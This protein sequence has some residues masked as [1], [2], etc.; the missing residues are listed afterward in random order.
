MTSGGED[1][2]HQS[3]WRVQ[4]PDILDLVASERLKLAAELMTWLEQLRLPVRFLICSR[5]ESPRPRGGSPAENAGSTHLQFVLDEHLAEQSRRRPTFRRTVFVTLSGTDLELP[6]SASGWLKSQEH[7]PPLAEGRWRERPTLLRAG[8]RYLTSL[9]LERLPGVEVAPGWLWSLAGTPGE[10]DLV[11]AVWPRAEGEADRSLRRRM[12]GLRARELAAGERGEV[13]DPRLQAALDSAARL[14][15]VLARSE[16][17][18]FDLAITV[19]V[20]GDTSEETRQVARQIHSRMTALRAEVSPAWCTQ[21]P[22]RLQTELLSTRPVGPRRVVQSTELASFWPWLDDWDGR[23]VG[24]VNLGRHLRTGAPVWLNLHDATAL[25][26]ANL[27]VV[28][29]SGSGKSYLGGLLGLEAVRLGVRTVVLDPENEHRRWCEAVA[30]QYLSLGESSPCGF[31]LLEMAEPG[32]APSAV[33]ELISLLCGQ[34][35]PAEIGQV[36]DAVRWTLAEAGSGTAMLSD[37]LPRLRQSEIGEVVAHR[38]LPWLDGTPGALFNSPGRGPA[39]ETATAVGLRELP[40]A[41]IPAA[42]LVVSHWL[43]SWIRSQEGRKQAIVDEAGLLAD[44]APLQRLMAQ[45]ARRI[46]KYQGSLV[47]LT[48]SAG[49]LLGSAPGEVMA[50]NSA[51]MLLGSQHPAAA[52]RLQQGFLLDDAQRQWLE[53]AGRGQFLLLLG[54]RRSPIQ[55]E[56]AAQYHRLLSTE[57]GP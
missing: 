5:R 18:L 30:G 33:A 25:P 44:N 48:Q 52:V 45:L 10:F 22:A 31:N 54:P 49:D 17:K 28:A 41:W 4:A 12:L 32:E 39:V 29:A 46:R 37:C 47:L 3:T 35:S 57:G 38:L 15:Q 36:S 11:L 13:G 16:G 7:P 2:G 24:A 55:I 42:T 19:T 40:A 6:T 34:L 43:W 1:D 27:G 9:W 51:T 26:N 50:V 14:R 8:G 56:T 20:A 23:T 53:R 21:G